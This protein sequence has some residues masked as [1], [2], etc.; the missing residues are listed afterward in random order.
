[1]RRNKGFTLIELLVV[2]AIIAILAA[3]L[4]PVFAQAR[5][6]ARAISCISNLKQIG[7]ASMMYI[8]DY[9]ETY[10]N[11]WGGNA[12]IVTKSMWR[13]SLLPYIQKYGDVSAASYDT[14]KYGGRG[15]LSCPDY[16]AGQN[17]GPSSY[18]YND[19]EYAAGGWL[20]T[21]V[22]PSGGLI[23]GSPAAR[24]IKPASLVMFCD[25]GEMG[26]G[27]V[28]AANRAADPGID[29]ADAYCDVSRQTGNCGPYN[30]KPEVWKPSWG[31]DWNVSVPGNNAD[32]KT[33]NNSGRRPLSRH[34]GAFNAVF[35]DGHAK[36]LRGGVLTSK[37][38]SEGDVM[39]NHD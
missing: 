7:T 34:F 25:S 23:T 10:M 6:R 30:F 16:P 31:V 11:G 1:M 13:Y 33:S 15:V 19:T 27:A 8:Q 18:G 26:G 24:I 20:G 14:S 21:D 38:G 4:F 9:D 36:A 39:R 29:A 37:L 3:I 17:T 35:G 2:I 12:D 22:V 28:G 32:W 5:A